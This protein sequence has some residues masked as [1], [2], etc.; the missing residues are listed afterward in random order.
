MVVE[1]GLEILLKRWLIRQFAYFWTSTR[2]EQ[3]IV[4]WAR[5]ARRGRFEFSHNRVRSAI[6]HELNPLRRQAMHAQVA[7]AL[8][9]LHGGADCE[10]LAYHYTCAAQWEKSLVHLEKA[11]ERALAVR[12]LD[13]ARR[14]CDQAIEVLSRLAAGARS[15]TQAERWRGERERIRDLRE[16]A[17]TLWA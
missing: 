13:T 5:G 6:Y 1:I 14:Y 9:N 3:D 11:V 7:A 8:E 16:N 15:E 2:R 12:A 10:A 4:L 17:T